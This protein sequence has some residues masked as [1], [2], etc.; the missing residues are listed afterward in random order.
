MCFQKNACFIN[1]AYPYVLLGFEGFSLCYV[2]VLF[3]LV[4]GSKNAV[5]ITVS[6][7]YIVSTE[8]IRKAWAELLMY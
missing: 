8:W 1:A 7:H 5:A 4:Y 6:L 3:S 2:Q